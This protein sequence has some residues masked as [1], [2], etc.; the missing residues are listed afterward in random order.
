MENFDRQ[1][2]RQYYYGIDLFKFL[3]AL[4]IVYTHT[5]CFDMGSVGK[6]VQSALSSAGV[7]FFFITSGFFFAR[8]LENSPNSAKYLLS[9]LK[10]MLKLYIVW[11]V[12][13]F[14]LSWYTNEL[15]HPDYSILLK[16]IYSL[17]CIL[18][19]GSMGVYWYILS[20]LYCSIILYFVYSHRKLEIPF[21]V[22]SFIFYIVGVIYASGDPD[23]NILFHLMH[24]V[25]GSERNF[26]TVGMLYTSIGYYFASHRSVY[27]K[28]YLL[29]L[30][31]LS[32]CL[33]TLELSF[34]RVR[35]SQL[36]VSMFLFLLALNLSC[37]SISQYSKRLRSLSTAI[38]LIH[39][40][41]ILIFDFYL[42]KSTIVDF[43]V[44][45][46]TSIFI[47]TLLQKLLPAKINRLLWGT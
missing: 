39:F 17:R 14:P 31:I 2:D 8:G 18:F 15:A 37:K 13:S 4:L 38:Y 46:F 7:P 47:Y 27:K 20:L 33:K 1:T 19:S 45:L 28:S 5:Y 43:T 34:L 42:Q 10:R 25:F 41:V 6:W 11:T 32:V 3:F 23:R 22:V 35:F 26:I 16:L 40:L 36:F 29:I 44:T 24:A 30:I 9:Y 21:Y 12:I